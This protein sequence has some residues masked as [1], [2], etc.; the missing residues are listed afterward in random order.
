M[1][2]AGGLHLQAALSHSECTLDYSVSLFVVCFSLNRS[3]V[4]EINTCSGAIMDLV[5]RILC[6]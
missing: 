1:G 5:T 3:L 6:L 4:T 2:L